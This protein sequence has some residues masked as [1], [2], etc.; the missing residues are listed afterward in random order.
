M[1]ANYA[2]E[3]VQFVLQNI[4]HDEMQDK[5][6]WFSTHPPYSDEQQRVLINIEQRYDTWMA[7]ERAAT[8]LAYGMKWA[9]SSGKEYLYQVLD[10]IGNAKSLGPRSH[11][12]EAAMAKYTSSKTEINERRQ[13]S[14]QKLTESC[15]LYRSLRLPIPNEPKFSA[16]RTG[17]LCSAASCLCWGTN[18]MPAY[19]IEA[20]G[21]IND[22]PTETDDFDVAWSALGKD[23]A[24]LGVMALKRVDSTYTV[25]TERYFS[26]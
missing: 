15:A 13:A 16:R 19:S 12:T 3:T 17:N 7:A 24:D 8:A 26:G 2:I 5:L 18:A 14:A 20:G 1:Y 25:D 4:V 21:E 22:A 11:E 9:E 6:Q 23:D 10:R